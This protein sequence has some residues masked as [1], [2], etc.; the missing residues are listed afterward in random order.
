MI[1]LL[2]LSLYKTGEWTSVGYRKERINYII[3]N[4]SLLIESNKETNIIMNEHKE[5]E[6]Q[7]YNE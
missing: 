7:G 1:T 3:L 5:K 4:I 2:V 6:C